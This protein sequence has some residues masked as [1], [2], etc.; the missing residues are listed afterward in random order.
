MGQYLGQ[1]R[2]CNKS[3]DRFL[4]QRQSA[5]RI[6]FAGC[7]NCLSAFSVIYFFAYLI[8]PGASII[9]GKLIGEFKQKEAYRAA[10]TCLISSLTI[11]ILLAAGLWYIKEPFLRFYGCTGDLYLEASAY[12][13][14][15]ILFAIIQSVDPILYFLNV[16]DGEATLT[17][18]AF[19]ADI[20][21]NIVLS[22]VLS[23]SF[24]IA[25]LGI[26]TCIG[27][28]LRIICYLA[29]YLR[30]SNNVK[31]HLC[32][33]LKLT[34]KSNCSQLQQLYVLSVPCSS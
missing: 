6:V 15:L 30:K 13:S 25:G 32:L 22:V 26:A 12:Y 5:W 3:H 18:V 19:V 33:D 27:L 16:S 34:K 11:G 21:A 8:A 9:Y 7:F 28:L 10:G 24:G 20:A 29:H 2:L 17:S 4:N 1:P 14:W 31:Y 23:R